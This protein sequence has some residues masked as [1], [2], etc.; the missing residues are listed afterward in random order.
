MM[1]SLD[2]MI[3]SI[4]GTGFQILEPP[5]ALDPSYYSQPQQGIISRL[6]QSDV[7]IFR[8][9]P[10]LL[11]PAQSQKYRAHLQLT[12]KFHIRYPSPLWMGGDAV[13]DAVLGWTKVDLPSPQL[14]AGKY[15]LDGEDLHSTWRGTQ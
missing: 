11:E 5:R 15:Q 8:K 1:G 6:P 13:T 7:H 9:N 10:H 14:V 3:C 2:G 4:D 12:S